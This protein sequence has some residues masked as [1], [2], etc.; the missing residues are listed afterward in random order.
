MI[1]SL[2]TRAASSLAIVPVK[3]EVHEYKKKIHSAHTKAKHQGPGC[4]GEILPSLDLVLP[5]SSRI[6]QIYIVLRETS[7]DQADTKPKTPS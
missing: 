5:S 1:L 6:W 3:G 7:N 4:V 2:E